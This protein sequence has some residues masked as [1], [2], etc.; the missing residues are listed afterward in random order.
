MTEQS[1]RGPSRRQAFT[2]AAGAGLAA[3]TIMAAS[4]EEALAQAADQGVSPTFTLLLVNDIYK[5][6]EVRGRG[7]FARL[8]AIA[9]AER[10]KGVPLLYAHAGDMFSPSLM[11]GFDQ[12]QHTLELLNVVPP[13]IFVPGNHEFDFGKDNYFKL[14]KLAKY[15]TF[16]ANLRAADG[17]VL[18]GH[19]DR[20]MV[21]LG[22]VKVGIFGV[23]LANTPLMSS[24]GDL[25]FLD[26]M[27]AVREQSRAL[28]EAGADMV[29]AV[30]HTDFSRDLEI[31]RSRLVDVLLTGHDHDL[32]VIYDNRTVMVE[33]GEEGEYVTAI[34]IYA[35]I[36]ERDGKRAVTWLP[37]FRI[38][39]SGSVTPD[40][41]ALAIVKAYEGELSKELDVALGATAVELDSRSA[42][43][44]SQETAIGNLIADA[45]RASTGADAAI[46]NGGGIRGNR[47]Y[48]AGTTL[49]RRDILTELPFGNSTAMVEITG[50]DI[51][52]ALENGVSQIDN[53]AG[54]FP[55]VSGMTFTVDQKASVG[56]RIM[57]LQVAGKDVDPAAKY[58]LATNDFLLGGGD[59]YT[60]LGR[61]RVLIGKTDG[62]LMASVVMAYVRAAGTIQSKVDGRIFL[63]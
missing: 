31:A 25:R 52:D 45:I 18:P 49:T 35:T 62:R 10:A 38:I 12:G 9:R 39:D 41:E 29:V 17:S 4:P 30:A 59:G 13:D 48:P 3:A 42:S 34:D 28:R 56:S 46:T 1:N 11:S 15:P 55:Q 21:D 2:I 61:G 33:S 23:T 57:A 27:T 20:A 51:K 37:R 8:A 16:A 32:R 54:R 44:R 7:G 40:P 58:K 60:A 6:A 50:K 5:M 47:Q 14:T 36:G 53:R 26:E 19:K 24:P 63:R 43:V 22:P